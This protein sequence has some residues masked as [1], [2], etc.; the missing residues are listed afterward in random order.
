MQVDLTNYKNRLSFKNKLGRALWNCTYWLLFRPFP[1]RL[2]NPWRILILSIFGAKFKGKVTIHQTVKIW[3]PWNLE[4]DTTGFAAQVK[5]YNVDKVIIKKCAV[6]SEG[7]YLC[8]ASHNI[9]SHNHELLTA[10]IVIESQVWM[11]VESFVGMGVTIGEG[12]VVGA[13][14]AV[15]KDVEP[16]TIVGGNPAKVINKR[17]IN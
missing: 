1:G 17:I 5:C 13:R 14:A 12:A 15:F 4:M 8:T 2:F 10:P 9:Y 3:A 11:A 16:W 7:A 6:I